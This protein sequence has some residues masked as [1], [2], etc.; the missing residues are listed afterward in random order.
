[1]IKEQ[2]FE[3]SEGSQQVS[4]NNWFITKSIQYIYNF[5]RFL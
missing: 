5:I 4:I 2:D 1:L 3:S